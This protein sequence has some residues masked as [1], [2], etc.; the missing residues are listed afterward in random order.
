MP[1]IKNLIHT[2]IHLYFKIQEKSAYS[3]ITTF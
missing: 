3:I 1:Q 2:E